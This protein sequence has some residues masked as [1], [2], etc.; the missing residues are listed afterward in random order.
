MPTFDFHRLLAESLWNPV[1]TTARNGGTHSHI[2]VGPGG[3]VIHQRKSMDGSYEL[4]MLDDYAIRPH[5]Q[6][7]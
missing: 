2:D 6:T 4:R 7:T 5:H 3:E 1:G